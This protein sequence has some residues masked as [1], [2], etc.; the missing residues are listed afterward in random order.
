[1]SGR[2]NASQ[3][4]SQNASNSANEEDV[5]LHSLKKLIVKLQQTF[6]A[7][8]TDVQK[9]FDEHKADLKKRFEDHKA[10]F[11]KRIEAQS[12]TIEQ[13]EI[14]LTAKIKEEFESLQKYIDQ[15]VSVLTSRITDI[16]NKVVTLEN[17]QKMADKFNC[18]TT[19]VVS[20]LPFEHGEDLE[21]K[22]DT[23]IKD[24]LRL[25][26]LPV[27]RVLRLNSHNGKPGLVKAQFRSLED[28]IRLLKVKGNLLQTQRYQR[29]FIRSS[30]THAERM[31]YHNMR[32]I[33]S[34]NP[35]LN[36]NY[37]LSGN[38][39]L[40]PKSN[41]PS[42]PITPKRR[43]TSS[44]PVAVDIPGLNPYALSYSPYDERPSCF[45][46]SPQHSPQRSPQHSPQHSPQRR[47]QH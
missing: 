3:N 37:R 25:H 11:K 2:R 33:L 20:N 32:M 30:Q 31:A 22:I 4:A 10:D 21:K 12:K 26:G 15:E 18:D 6:D 36:K 46:H 43:I 28:K 44:T 45:L 34:S 19:V 16:E 8:K 7:H 35:E 42:A 40:I 17:R 14:R 41:D 38:G 1:M 5:N 47:P 13:V 39:K 9:R 24:G 27:I 23:L 29:V